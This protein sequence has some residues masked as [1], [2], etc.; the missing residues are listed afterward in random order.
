MVV[1]WDCDD[2]PAQSHPNSAA[3]ARFAVVAYRIRRVPRREA[4][5]LGAR[6]DKTVRR[7][8]DL[9]ARGHNST[10]GGRNVSAQRTGDFRGGPREKARAATGPASRQIGFWINSAIFNFV[11]PGYTRILTAAGEACRARDYRLQFHSLDETKGSLEAL[12]AGDDVTGGLAGNLVVGGVNRLALQYLSELPCPMLLVDLLVADHRLDFVRIDYA[13]GARQ[14]IEHLKALGHD[15][16]GFIGF[17]GSEKYEAYWQSLEVC[18]LRYNPRCVE[19]L[20]V[21]DL[22][23]GM[24]AGYRSVQKLMAAKRLPTAL[25]VTNDYVALGVMEA[26]SVAGIPVPEQISIVGCDDLE[27]S[28]RP[29]TTIHVDLGEVGRLATNTLLDRIENGASGAKQLVTGKSGHPRNYRAAGARGRER[30]TGSNLRSPTSAA[31]EISPPGLPR[32]RWYSRPGDA[33][34]P[35]NRPC[36]EDRSCTRPAP[37]PAAGSAAS[38]PRQP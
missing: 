1:P 24:M 5:A 10:L 23:P 6:D 36:P 13:S 7:F 29:L 11:Q 14:A 17:P 30:V 28:A 35:R 37:G 22:L 32:C 9:G 3:V 25:L 31:A 21:S 38:L 2:R 19:L 26:L 27:L 18:G 33:P 15:N 34:G 12:F 16:I 8:Q 20:S 4:V